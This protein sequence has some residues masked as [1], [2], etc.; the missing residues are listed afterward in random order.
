MGADRED[1]M[2]GRWI[3]LVAVLLAAVLAGCG[4]D[5][6]ESADSNGSDAT[7]TADDDADADA[8][9]D[10]EPEA[11]SEPEEPEH[12]TYVVQDGDTLS[13]I[14]ER[15]DVTVDELVELNELEDPDVLFVGD[16]L[17]IP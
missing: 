15:H 7:E 8:E 9:A 5:D 10:P 11:G 6:D 13:S 2:R 17:L 12:E 4:G 16:E 1:S 3:T 14:A